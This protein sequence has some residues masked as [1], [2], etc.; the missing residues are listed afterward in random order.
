M[1]KWKEGTGFSLQLENPFTT[2]PAPITD[3][4]ILQRSPI[5]FLEEK[6]RTFDVDQLV[7]FI[8]TRYDIGGSFREQHFE[9]P[10]GKLPIG[11]IRF[12]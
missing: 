3:C 10:I 7:L 4:A 1:Y 12:L 5:E 6:H 8:K 2:I 9:I 11:K